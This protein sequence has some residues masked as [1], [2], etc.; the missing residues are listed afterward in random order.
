[1]GEFRENIKIKSTDLTYSEIVKMMFDAAKRGQPYL[2]IGG[3][4][5]STIISK[6]KENELRLFGKDR[7]DLNNKKGKE[8]GKLTYVELISWIHAKDIE[9]GKETLINRLFE[10]TRIAQNKNQGEE[11]SI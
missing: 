10:T 2:N 7:F 5:S 6:L 3:Y 9:S 1:M 8:H 11:L 4:I